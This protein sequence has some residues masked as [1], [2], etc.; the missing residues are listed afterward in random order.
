MESGDSLE[1]ENAGEQVTLRPVRARGVQLVWIEAYPLRVWTS[2]QRIETKCLTLLRVEIREAMQ[3]NLSTFKQSAIGF[4]AM[5]T[6]N[7][8]FFFV[9][10]YG[11]PTVDMKA[12]KLDIGGLVN[13]PQALTL[14]ALKARPKKEAA[15]LLGL[16]IGPKIW[17]AIAQSRV[18]NVFVQNQNLI[19]S[20]VLMHPNRYEGCHRRNAL[21]GVCPASRKSHRRSGRCA[22]RQGRDWP[23]RRCHRCRARASC[24]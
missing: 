23:C 14:D 18:K 1:T 5:S 2:Q 20:P 19:L 8:Q 17:D 22:A 21:S 16:T 11:Y 9:K 4:L 6:P 7:E 12:W 15:L 24:A 10:H 13:E 3:A